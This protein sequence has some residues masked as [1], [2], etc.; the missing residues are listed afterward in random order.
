MKICKLHTQSLREI[1]SHY[2]WDLERRH[3]DASQPEHQYVKDCF[4]LLAQLE[5]DLEKN[6]ENE[7]AFQ[8]T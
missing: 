6:N 3:L 4:E 1:L 7:E 8:A 2:R 5:K